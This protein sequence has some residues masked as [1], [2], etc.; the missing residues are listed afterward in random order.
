MKKFIYASFLTTI[1]FLVFNSCTKEEVA[2]EKTNQKEMGVLSFGG[3]LNDLGEKGSLNKGSEEVQDIPHCSTD[4]PLFV[5]VSLKVLNGDTWEWFKNS[6]EEKIVIQVNPNGSDLDGDGVFDAWFTQESADLELEEGKYRLEY[7]AVASEEEIIYMAPRVPE[8]NLN[9]NQNIQYFNYVDRPLPLEITII[10]GV[11]YYQPVE[12]LCFEEHYAFAFGYL[13]FDFNKSPL[14]YLCTYGNV[15]DEEGR[16]IP[17]QFKMKVWKDINQNDL[18]VVAQNERKIFND[19]SGTHYYADALCFPLPKLEDSDVYYAKIWLLEDDDEILIRKGSFNANEL[20]QIFNEEQEY[21][22]YHFREAC[23]EEGDNFELL[24]DITENEE[25]CEEE[26]QDPECVVCDNDQGGKIKQI[27]VKYIGDSTIDLMVNHNGPGGSSYQI[28]NGE[29]STSQNLLLQGQAS[30]NGNPVPSV[31]TEMQFMISGTTYDLHTSCS[32]PLYPGQIFGN[33]LFE[34][35]SA[36]NVSNQS[37]CV[38]E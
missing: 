30:N 34:V 7:F 32:E 38:I 20:A 5:Y 24:D 36:I 25:A 29:V 3:V 26:P 18:L 17:A 27:T 11:K 19:E 14:I 35:I 33:G 12:V 22:Y 15:C 23:C 9:H 21:Y 6:N 16:H 10:P 8:E 4:A 31:W 37:I 13:F 1:F 28:F 2:L